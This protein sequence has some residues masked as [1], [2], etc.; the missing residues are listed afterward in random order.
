MTV[1]RSLLLPRLVVHVNPVAVHRLEFGTGGAAAL[2]LIVDP[3]S[4]PSIDADLVAAA[5]RLTRAESQVAAAL[6]EGST[7]REIAAST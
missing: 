4:R 6:A 5:F 3:G 2:V 1:E 7:V